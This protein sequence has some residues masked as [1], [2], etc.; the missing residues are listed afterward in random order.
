M[1]VLR[2]E[3]A[4]PIK[5]H[6]AAWCA[7]RIGFT[8]VWGH[9]KALAVFDDE[10][11]VAVVIY[12]N[13]DPEAGVIEINAAS[14]SKR[15]LTREVLREIFAYPF[16]RLGYQLVVARVSP[17]NH[18]ENGRGTTRIFRS[19]GFSEYRIPRL[20]GRDE[21]EII[22]TLSDD[23]WRAKVGQNS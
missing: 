5:A 12:S 17:S 19:F 2:P 4:E 23:Q 13:W 7:S 6:L 22:F 3:D 14:I 21:D 11:L 10:E 8:R 20:R 16:D 1:N 15:W 18:S 9:C